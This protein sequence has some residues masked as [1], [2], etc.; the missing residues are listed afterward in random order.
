M[1]KIITSAAASLSCLLLVSCG[2][3][4]P[5]RPILPP[6]TTV[7]TTTS[8][9]VSQFEIMT[10]LTVYERAASFAQFTEGTTMDEALGKK[11]LGVEQLRVG[12]TVLD[13]EELR[14]ELQAAMERVNE[15]FTDAEFEAAFGETKQNLRRFFNDADNDGW[16]IDGRH[17]EGR[18]WPHDGPGNGND[19]DGWT[20]QMITTVTRR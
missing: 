5:S 20:A 10:L 6:T 15:T 3:S 16:F 18:D 8:V 17:G 19:P 9:P 2:D 1:K 14:N 7:P 11:I 13:N 12:T 4:G